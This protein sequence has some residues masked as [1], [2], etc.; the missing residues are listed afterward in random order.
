MR[1]ADQMRKRWQERLRTSSIF[2]DGHLEVTFI[3]LRKTGRNPL[4]WIEISADLITTPVRYTGD[5]HVFQQV[6]R[7][8]WA[9]PDGPQS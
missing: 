5:M 9:H 3:I 1:S 4:S 7:G 8:V 6:L 2:D